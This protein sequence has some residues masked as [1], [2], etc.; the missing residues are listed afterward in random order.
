[1]LFEGALSNIDLSEQ[2]LTTCLPNGGCVGGNPKDAMEFAIKKGGIPTEESYPY[3]PY[4]VQK[5]D[6]C[7]PSREIKV[8]DRP[9]VSY[10]NIEDQ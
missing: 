9:M 2:F 4:T 1:M 5:E 6:I 3:L 7:Y 10:F 8:G